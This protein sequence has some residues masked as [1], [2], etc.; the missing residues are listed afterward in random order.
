MADRNPYI[1]S[2]RR[3]D[4]EEKE[5]FNEE[6]SQRQFAEKQAKLKQNASHRTKEEM[7]KAGE[8]SPSTS[9]KAEG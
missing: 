9:E 4:V 7:D 5:R 3:M 6:A 2:E 1:P 8:D